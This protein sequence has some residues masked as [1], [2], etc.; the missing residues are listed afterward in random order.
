MVIGM[1]WAMGEQPKE[2][3]KLENPKLAYIER[4]LEEAYEYH[5]EKYI[6]HPDTCHI[7]PKQ[8]DGKLPT[9]KI[10]GNEIKL[11]RDDS[12]LLNTIWIGVGDK[13]SYTI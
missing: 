12:I 5:F 10:K 9:I 3:L 7:N 13:E 11:F 8:I 2:E 6:L 1:M 4:S